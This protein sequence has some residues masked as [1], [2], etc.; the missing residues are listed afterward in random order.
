MAVSPFN[1]RPANGLSPLLEPQ[2][3]SDNF[4]EYTPKIAFAEQRIFHITAL[5][6]FN[7][8]ADAETVASCQQMYVRFV[9]VEYFF[10]A[11]RLLSI[12]VS[13]RPL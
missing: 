11:N 10:M 4:A 7:I 13:H 12:V 2:E 1:Y 5:L 8:E 6:S 9:I 3:N